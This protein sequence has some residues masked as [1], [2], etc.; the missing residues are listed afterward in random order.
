MEKDEQQ[1]G[2][3]VHYVIKHFSP[4]ES[5]FFIA[6]MHQMLQTVKLTRLARLNGE[7]QVALNTFFDLDKDHVISLRGDYT[8]FSYTI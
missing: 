7:N 4:R 3:I 1:N 8:T 5:F 2:K 6:K